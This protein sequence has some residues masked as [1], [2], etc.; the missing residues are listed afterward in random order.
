MFGPAAAL[1]FVALREDALAPWAKWIALGWAVLA[2]MLL[3]PQKIVHEDHSPLSRIL[4]WL[5]DP[6]FRLSMR[7]R[8]LVIF[9][10]IASVASAVY[11]WSKMG[12]EFMPPLDEG[13]LLYMPTTA[14][15]ISVDKSR[16]LLQQTDK[17]IKTIPEVVSVHGKIGRA[18]TAT[19]PAPL[20]MIE[21]VVR[22]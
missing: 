15:S 21:T 11:P 4:Q 22:L 6:I 14:P 17:L 10:A 1:Y 12:T 3:V 18:E 8:W 13:D 16:E 20:S 5:Y 19:D 9:F 7:Y 2:G